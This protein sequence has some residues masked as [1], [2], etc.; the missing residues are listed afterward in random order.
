MTQVSGEMALGR[1][2]WLPYKQ[3]CIILYEIETHKPVSEKSTLII[4]EYKLQSA[5][6]HLRSNMP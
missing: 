6:T 5:L 4:S 3:L 1:L 2:D